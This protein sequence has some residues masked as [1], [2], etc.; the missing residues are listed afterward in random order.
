MNLKKGK[1]M[2]HGGNLAKKTVVD[3]SRFTRKGRTDREAE[4]GKT[5]QDLSSD[6]DIAISGK[7]KKGDYHQQQSARKRSRIQ[8]TGSSVAEW[9]GKYDRIAKVLFRIKRGK[10]SYPTLG[11]DWGG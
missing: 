1:D 2:S 4:I 5:R 11:R 8:I 6:R 7:R 9:E 3:L 10:P